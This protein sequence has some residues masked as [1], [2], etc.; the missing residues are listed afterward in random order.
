MDWSI[1]AQDEDGA[2]ITCEKGTFPSL[3]KWLS[4]LPEKAWMMGITRDRIKVVD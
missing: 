1:L 3:D 4:G 2:V